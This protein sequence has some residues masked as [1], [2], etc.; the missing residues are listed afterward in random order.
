MF[1][2]KNQKVPTNFN[3]KNLKAF[4][5]KRLIGPTTKV[6]RIPISKMSPRAA[7]YIDICANVSCSNLERLDRYVK[8]L[9]PLDSQEAE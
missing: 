7:H 5:A 4:T 2:L 8:A 6:L 1:W 9:Q 3:Y